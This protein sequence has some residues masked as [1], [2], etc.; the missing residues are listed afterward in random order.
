MRRVVSLKVE[1]KS[2]FPDERMFR[3]LRK[4][5]TLAGFSL[6]EPPVT[7]MH[8]RHLDSADGAFRA[9]GYACR[10]RRQDSQ[11]LAMLKG[12]GAMSGA[13][14]HQT[15]HLAEPPEALTP[16]DWPQNAPRDMALHLG[17]CPMQTTPIW[18]MRQ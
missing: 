12:L 5:T 4:A 10:N 15:E 18:E 2:S 3:W 11:P 14:H 17:I 9:T 8:D 6:E 13:T 7:G 16:W 1:A